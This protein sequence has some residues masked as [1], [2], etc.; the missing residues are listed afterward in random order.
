L[1]K[2]LEMRMNIKRWS[3]VTLAVATLV[4]CG[5]G[6]SD[7]GST[8]FGSGAGSA[9][10]PGSE[11]PTT[12]GGGT[13]GTPPVATVPTT[14]SGGIS[15]VANGVPNQRFMS[16]SVGTY[17]LNWQKD[18]DETNVR[19]QVA[20]TAGNPVPEGSVIQFSTEG[21]Q[22]QTSC[23][24]TGVK[25]GASNISA[26]SVTFSTQDFR[27][28]DGFVNIIAWM[29]GEEAYKDLNA[30]GRYDQGEPFIDTGRIYRDDDDSESYNASF[31]EL[32]IG[33]TLGSTPGI[34]TQPCALAPS[35]IN[36]NGRPLSI[37][38]TCDGV[39]G[40]TLIRTSVRLPVSR[41]DRIAIDVVQGVYDGVALRGVVAYTRADRGPTDVLERPAAPNGVKLKVNGTLTDCTVSIV[42]DTVVSTVRETYHEVRG[43][44]EGCSGKSVVIEAG[45]PDYGTA[46][47]TYTLP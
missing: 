13:S 33:A 39:W 37:D 6:G 7:A 15:T 32:S 18:G 8:T 25:S 10:G 21:G 40:K 3:F 34:G 23:T 30:N 45:L 22:I 2:E 31:D 12:T 4:A 36:I 20:D 47:A 42:P 5:G 35:S 43:E 46:R 1:I 16:M 14:S 44:G 9:G 24:T 41:P 27:P 19:I 38:N 26:C 29:E 28:L 11:V 17:N